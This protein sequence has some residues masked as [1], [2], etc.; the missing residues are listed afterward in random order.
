[1]KKKKTNK[2]ENQYK[3]NYG[4][5][6]FNKYYKKTKSQED[7]ERISYFAKKKIKEATGLTS[8]DLNNLMI[9]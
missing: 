6:N 2:L 3:P 8:D 9:K 4:G 7:W 5:L 1:M